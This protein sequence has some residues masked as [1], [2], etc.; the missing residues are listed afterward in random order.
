MQLA[1]FEGAE[2]IWKQI[3]TYQ[4]LLTWI[5]IL[6]AAFFAYG[7]IQL[8]IQAVSKRL[9]VEQ[10]QKQRQIATLYASAANAAARVFDM[11]AE[12]LEGS[13]NCTID[14]VSLVTYENLLR[15][16]GEL[17]VDITRT[18]I[19]VF[20]FLRIQ[21]PITIEHSE[22]IQNA[23]M[24]YLETRENAS[25]E[26]SIAHIRQLLD[27]E[28]DVYAQ[29]MWDCAQIF[30]S[31]ATWLEHFAEN[32]HV[33]IMEDVPKRFGKLTRLLLSAPVSEAEYQR[34]K[35]LYDSTCDAEKGTPQYC[36]H[37]SL[38]Y[39]LERQKRTRQ[40]T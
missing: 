36:T 10:Q 18:V 29:T 13:P 5:P 17:P 30:Y 23:V 4:T 19:Q 1:Y 20:E 40:T 35:T 6:L 25:A 2:F 14:P 31:L 7:S 26:G 24:N 21:N 32:G 9:E 39:V 27:K 15:E 37:K 33:I 8:Q 34:Y 22:Q 12:I 16:L 38:G 3:R 11:N 28:L